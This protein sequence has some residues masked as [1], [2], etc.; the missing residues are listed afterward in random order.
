MSMAIHVGHTQNEETTPHTF[1]S[2]TALAAAIDC[3]TGHPCGYN[4]VRVFAG[5]E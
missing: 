4:T 3:V 5:Y 2:D 1:G